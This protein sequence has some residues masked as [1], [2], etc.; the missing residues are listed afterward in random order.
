MFETLRNLL[1]GRAERRQG[2]FE[3]RLRFLDWQPDDNNADTRSLPNFDK[4]IQVHPFFGFNGAPNPGEH[5]NF[6]FSCPRNF[7]LDEHG[8][9]VEGL[10]RDNYFLIG[11]FGGSF[12]NRLGREA[13][14]WIEGA[15]RPAVAPR[16]PVVINLAFGGHSLPQPF[17]IYSYFSSMVDAALFIDGVNELCNAIP[18]N[19]AGCPPEY[20]K[21]AHYLYK[22]CRAEMSPATFEL[23]T[24]M[25]QY[26]K[27]NQLL[28]KLSLLPV[29]R[30]FPFTH[31]LWRLLSGGARTAA[32]RCQEEIMNMFYSRKAFTSLTDEQLLVFAASRWT[33]WHQAAHVLC[34]S[35]NVIDLHFLQPTPLAG[36]KKLSEA[37][38]KHVRTNPYSSLVRDGYPLLLEQLEHLQASDFPIFSMVDLYDGCSEDVWR[39]FGYPN[40]L[41]WK[42]AATYIGERLREALPVSALSEKVHADFVLNAWCRIPRSWPAPLLLLH[43]NKP[44]EERVCVVYSDVETGG[45]RMLGFKTMLNANNTEGVKLIVSVQAAD[46]VPGP[47]LEHEFQL[48]APPKTLHLPLPGARRINIKF[49]VSTVDG[50]KDNCFCGTQILDPFFGCG[51]TH[52]SGQDADEHV[53]SS[54]KGQSPAL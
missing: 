13:K 16:E 25:L 19:K 47:W 2:L 33:R 14:K 11:I 3:E 41:G 28:T 17:F 26:Q 51:E 43:P 12:A 21:A 48:Q 36:C 6:G 42:I 53:D 7:V 45:A 39:G 4:K 15:L 23:S 38:L 44:A 40:A 37:E 30:S 46:G 20:P 27:L 35:E 1:R 34:Q 49:E 10:D 52:P 54:Y 32:D 18:N 50:A 8:Y 9:A 24:R 31:A 5:N 22:I 29:V